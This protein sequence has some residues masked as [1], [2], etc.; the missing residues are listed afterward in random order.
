MN[1]LHCD[2]CDK[3]INGEYYEVQ[4]RNTNAI[5]DSL[6]LH[7][8]KQICAECFGEISEADND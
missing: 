3:V 7:R 8:Y 5:T 1:R 6:I 4:I 2:K